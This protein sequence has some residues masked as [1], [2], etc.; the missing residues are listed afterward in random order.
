M[1]RKVGMKWLLSLQYRERLPF[2][3][4][5]GESLAKDG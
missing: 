1:G 2:T 3:G 5:G 4:L